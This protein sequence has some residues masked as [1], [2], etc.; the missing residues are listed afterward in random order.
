MNPASL[1]LGTFVGVMVLEMV[2]YYVFPQWLARLAVIPVGTPRTVRIPPAILDRG[3]VRAGYRA[4]ARAPVQLDRIAL[5]SEISGSATKGTW[6]GTHGWLRLTTLWFGWNRTLGV[7][8][9]RATLQGD[10]VRLDARLM[11]M[12]V[13][14]VLTLPGALVIDAPNVLVVPMLVVFVFS[15]LLGWYMTVRRIRDDVDG[16]LLQ[17]AYAIERAVP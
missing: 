8:H 13:A 11:P 2:L 15:V 10:V 1:L 17:I 14:F 12:P 9:L 7:A 3:Q 5:P 6:L 4:T 16:A